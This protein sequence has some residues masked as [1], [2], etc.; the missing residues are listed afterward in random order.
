MSNNDFVDSVNLKQSHISLVNG[1]FIRIIPDPI[2]IPHTSVSSDLP[3]HNPYSSTL[4]NSSVSF[5][6]VLSLLTIIL[7]NQEAMQTDNVDI[8]TDLMFRKKASYPYGLMIYNSVLLEW[9]M[10][11]LIYKLA[12]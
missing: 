6:E 3:S 8:N 12:L 4:P 10:N 7:R 9:R 1:V 5:P 11:S 2:P